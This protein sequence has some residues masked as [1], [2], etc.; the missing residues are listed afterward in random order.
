MACD[1][2]RRTLRDRQDDEGV[3]AVCDVSDQHG[4]DGAED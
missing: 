2:A 1:G 4:V 3:W